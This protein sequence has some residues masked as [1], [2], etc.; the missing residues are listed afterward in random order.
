MM[1]NAANVS[2]ADT[3]LLIVPQFHVMAWGFPFMCMLAG[4]N[5]VMPG[6]HLQPAA[7]I[8]MLGGNALRLPTGCPPS[9]WA[10]TKR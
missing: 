9:G 7:I 1:P 3:A 6:L 4:A 2:S 5:M 8:D 10:C